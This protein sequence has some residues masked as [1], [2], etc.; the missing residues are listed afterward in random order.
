MP[1]FAIKCGGKREFYIFGPDAVVEMIPDQ[2]AA[3]IISK[4]EDESLLLLAKLN[5]YD[6]GWPDA[7]GIVDDFEPKFGS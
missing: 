1:I 7:C 4:H 6:H 2:E 5:G 3:A